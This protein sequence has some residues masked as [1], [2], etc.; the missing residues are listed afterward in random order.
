MRKSVATGFIALAVVLF[1]LS[2][3]SLVR[4]ASEAE[5]LMAADEWWSILSRIFVAIVV[6]VIS[7]VALRAGRLRW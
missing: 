4:L 1:T 5:V 3:A 6:G 2:I 7:F